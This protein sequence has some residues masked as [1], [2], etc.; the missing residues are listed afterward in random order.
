MV[1]Y[2]TTAAAEDFLFLTGTSLKFGIIQKTIYLERMSVLSQIGQ[3][4]DVATS[5][6]QEIMT[7]NNWHVNDDEWGH[8]ASELVQ[9]NE[10]AV[11][12]EPS[13]RYDDH[14][15]YNHF[16]GDAGELKNWHF[17]TIDPDY[18]PSVPHG[19]WE[20]RDKPKLD[21]YLGWVYEGSKQTGRLKRKSIV[22]LWN[23]EKFR[24]MAAEAIKYY[25][26]NHPHYKGWRVADPLRLPR[27]RKPF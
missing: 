5:F 16:V 9:G 15:D 26:T 17:R 8:D 24:K 23:N 20:N 7:K 14:D 19:H 27:R 11:S 3:P 22:D 13:T 4:N 18:F 10:N 2:L 25:L 6:A 1:G 21:A 12:V